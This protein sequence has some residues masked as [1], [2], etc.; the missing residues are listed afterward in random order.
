MEILNIALDDL[1][2][3]SNNPKTRKPDVDLIHSIKDNGILNPLL[4]RRNGQGYILIGGARRLLAAKELGLKTVPCIVRVEQ[5][6]NATSLLI[7]DN[8]HRKNMNCYEEYQV[9]DKMLL[10]MSVAEVAKKLNKS[11]QY[12]VQRAALGNLIPKMVEHIQDDIPGINSKMAFIFSRLSQSLQKSLYGTLR[13]E[14]SGKGIVCTSTAEETERMA[15]NLLSRSFFNNDLN[16]EDLVALYGEAENLGKASIEEETK[17]LFD[18][19][20]D[21]NRLPTTEDLKEIKKRF[22]TLHGLTKVSTNNYS[23]MEGVLQSDSWRLAAKEDDPE[24]IIE[25]VYING[26]NA[27]KLVAVV[28]VN[29]KKEEAKKKIPL[30]DKQRKERKDKIVLNKATNAA[31]TTLFGILCKKKC[32]MDADTVRFVIDTIDYQKQAKLVKM[33]NPEADI[34]FGD[35]QKVLFKC[36][37]NMKPIDAVMFLICA[38]QITCKP[39]ELSKLYGMKFTDLVRESKTDILEQEKSK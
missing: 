33:F 5:E 25:A 35:M 24:N 38:P 3:D 17:S 34:N 13:F 29:K 6:L 36:I 10:S 8:L 18:D 39:D 26:P 2:I 22:K 1:H 11:V 20:A 37:S 30:T 27:G 7:A 31:H 14:K 21:S 28:K 9:I 16:P 15:T 23:T 19:K 4:V 32:S 12:I